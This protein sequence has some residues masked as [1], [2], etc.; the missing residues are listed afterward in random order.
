MSPLRGFKP[1]VLTFSIIISTL[2]VLELKNWAMSSFA[3]TQKSGY[4]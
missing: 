4:I 2:L 3:K 1:S